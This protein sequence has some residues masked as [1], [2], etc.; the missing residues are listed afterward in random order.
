MLTRLVGVLHGV[1]RDSF[2]IA[3]F[4]DGEQW[5]SGP[6]FETLSLCVNN[7]MFNKYKV[8]NL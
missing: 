8:I 3:C 6:F 5:V 4:E 2:C 1:G 7:E